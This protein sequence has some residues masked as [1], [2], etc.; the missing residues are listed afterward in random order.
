MESIINFLLGVLQVV[1][2]LAAVFIF[3]RTGMKYIQQYNDYNDYHG[4]GYRKELG[5]NL[6]TRFL[7]TN[8]GCWV[9]LWVVYTIIRYSMYH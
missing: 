9:G 8:L 2:M 6:L 4:Y 7:V 1:F 3:F 5:K